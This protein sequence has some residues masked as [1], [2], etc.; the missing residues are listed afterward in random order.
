[1]TVTQQRVRAFAQVNRGTRSYR[2]PAV[3]L[4]RRR[5]GRLGPV[6][7]TQLL[8]IELV[9]IGMLAAASRSALMLT[10][11]A[12]AG[13]LV[14]GVTLGRRRGRWW[15]EHLLLVRQYRRR[16]TRGGS[17]TD[18]R[19][20]A[21]RILAPNLTVRNISAADG[22]QV[23]VAQDDGGWYAVL[24]A[25]P[26]TPLSGDATSPLPLDVLVAALAEAEQPGSTLQIVHHT[27]TA[28]SPGL[29]PASPASQSYRQLL[30]LFGSAPASMTHTTWVA[31]RLDARTL[32]EL[33]GDAPA[34]LDAAPTVVAG[35]IRRVGTLLRHAGI[36]Y[37]VL[38]ADGLVAALAYSCDVEHPMAHGVPPWEDWTAWH[39]PRL[40]H[41]SFWLRD[42][43]PL[44]QATPLLD[45]LS[46]VPVA[47]SS[48]S[49]SMAYEEG[50]ESVDLRCL[51][52]VAAPAD[53]LLGLCRAITDGASQARA[54]LFPL[55]GEQGPAVYASAPTGGGL[56]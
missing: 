37:H 10:G 52:R 27:I 12:T 6:H 7:L 20:A 5:P 13:L 24:A 49:L 21:L 55:D 30:A 34:D 19:L 15:L 44:A 22:A 11:V 38:D 39:S 41:R 51:L 46:S 47:M 42:W 3:L 45:W 16:Q 17:H 2:E 50:K 18:P 40:A 8:L 4:P 25:A 43:P 1:M 35:L 48:L 23:G 31:V 14:L 56:R 53:D 32:A 36:P 28:P 29:H 26:N 33:Q 9:L 54:G